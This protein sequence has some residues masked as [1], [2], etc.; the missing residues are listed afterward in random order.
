MNTWQIDLKSFFRMIELQWLK[1]VRLEVQRDANFS[2][3]VICSWFLYPGLQHQ[4]E[5]STQTHISIFIMVILLWNANWMILLLVFPWFPLSE[6]FP[7]GV[8]W[9]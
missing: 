3:E 5:N 2:K 6:E 4:S 8:L 7:G 9:H 1:Q